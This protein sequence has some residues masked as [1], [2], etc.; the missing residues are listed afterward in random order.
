M[1][2]PIFRLLLIFPH[3][4]HT[5]DTITLEPLQL[6][7][8]LQLPPLVQILDLLKLQVQLVE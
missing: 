8:D 2:P 7:L 6:E 3:L 4:H 5:Q 1:L